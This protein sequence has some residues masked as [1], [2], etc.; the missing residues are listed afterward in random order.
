MKNCRLIVYVVL[1][2]IV[3]MSAKGQ[4]YYNPYY[5]PY[6]N[7]YLTQ[8]RMQAA[9]EWGRN[10]YQKTLEE[11]QRQEK[12]DPTS[13][14]ARICGYIA[15]NNLEEAE[16]W[17]GYLKKVDKSS[18]YHYFGI[19]YELQGYPYLAKEQYR[20]GMKLGNQF[21]KQYLNRLN[22]EGEMNEEQKM[23]VR[24]YYR[25]LIAMSYNMTNQIINSTQNSSHQHSHSYATDSQKT[26]Q[27]SCTSCGGTGIDS[28]Y[29]YDGYTP[30]V[31]MMGYY[32][33]S[34]NKCPYCGYYTAHGHDKCID[35]LY[36][37]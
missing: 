14:I 29:H 20:N 30:S 25:D 8:Q 3:C 9:E 28:R 16:E 13:C 19:V 32:N 6:N 2:V 7:P 35:C 4:Y 34:G 15:D 21:S 12:A 31:S 23:Q 36:V 37:R 11:L 24:K 26:K 27:A 5:T 22:S 10:L 1:S 18:G 17:C 33:N